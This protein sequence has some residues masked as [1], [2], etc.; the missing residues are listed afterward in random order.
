MTD[1]GGLTAEQ[2]EVLRAELKASKPTASQATRL[3][4]LAADAELFHAPDGEAHISFSVSG[5][6]ETHRLKS[7]DATGW[8]RR[9]FY[10]KGVC[11]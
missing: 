6:R 2:A 10:E 8:L 7:R 9:A 1:N 11:P 3:V 4:E 5:R